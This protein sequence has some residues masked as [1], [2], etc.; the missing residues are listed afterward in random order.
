MRG[1]LFVVGLVC[2]TAC[3]GAAASHPP[4]SRPLPSKIVFGND[5]PVTLAVP[6]GYDNA[7]PIPLLLVLHGYTADGAV[8]ASYLGMDKLVAEQHILLA[9]PDGVMN[10]TGTRFWNATDGC[11]DFDGTQVDDVAYL[12]RLITDIGAEYNVDPKRVY[13]VGHSNGAFMA[14][15]MACDRANL[16]AAIT[17]LEGATWDD[18]SKCNPSEPVSAVEIHGTLDAVI[19]YGGNPFGGI[20]GKY[21]SAAGSIDRWKG[22]D[23]CTVASERQVEH[24]DLDSLL[25]GAETTIDRVA[26]CPAGIGLELWSVQGGSHVPLLTDEFHTDVWRWLAAHPKP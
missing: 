20:P 3:G 18:A 24:L 17:S 13:I 16:I 4:P 11:C 9:A 1:R 26:G 7:Q 15:R 12:T 19:A 6:A 8:Q 25:L 10:K 2:I 22:Y 21:P 14:Y 5:R 23:H